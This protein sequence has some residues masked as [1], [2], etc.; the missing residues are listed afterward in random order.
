MIKKEVRY[1]EHVDIG[2]PKGP[3]PVKSRAGQIAR[4]RSIAPA[5]SKNVTKLLSKKRKAM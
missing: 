4:V 3:M 1:H 5:V 2:G